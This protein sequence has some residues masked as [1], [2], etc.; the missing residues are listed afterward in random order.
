MCSRLWVRPH[1]AG[2]V[3]DEPNY[4]Y[5]LLH[6]QR[7]TDRPKPPTPRRTTSSRCLCTFS[8]SSSGRSKQSHR[9]EYIAKPNDG[10]STRP[11]GIGNPPPPHAAGRP[12][13]PNFMWGGMEQLSSML[14]I[15]FFNGAD[16]RPTK[17]VGGRNTKK[18]IFFT[19]LL[20][21]VGCRRFIAVCM[22]IC[23][24]IVY[25]H[26]CTAKLMFLRGWPNHV[27]FVSGTGGRRRF[28]VRNFVGYLRIRNLLL[29]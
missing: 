13:E 7:P 15:F 23:H 20:R 24:H 10:P 5:S 28:C 21:R 16:S 11:D 3:V 18:T 25:T 22:Y 9:S 2:A 29:N 26:I 27:S 19:S 6:H 8:S 1:K 17:E 14:I 4:Y 12:Y